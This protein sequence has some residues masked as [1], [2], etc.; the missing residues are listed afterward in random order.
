VSNKRR[1]GRGL[2]SR[3]LLLRDVHRIMRV[4]WRS[5]R[6]P[7]HHLVTLPPPGHPTTKLEANTSR[8]KALSL[9]IFLPSVVP[10]SCGSSGC[11]R[12]W[13]RVQK[14]AVGAVFETGKT[15]LVNR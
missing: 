12:L 8:G 3:R 1:E 11:P 7:R 14:T 5:A 13:A 9:L 10:P 4:R 2:G 6:P 15:G